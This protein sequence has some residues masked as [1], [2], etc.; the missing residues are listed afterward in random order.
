MKKLFIILGLL[1][2]T[3]CGNEELVLSG[4]SGEL[5]RLST[6]EFN[7]QMI[8]VEGI[9]AFDEMESIYDYDFDD[10][11]DIDSDLVSEYNVLYNED[12]EHFLAVFKAVDGEKE[13]LVSQMKD[14]TEDLE[15]VTFVEYEGYLIYVS[16]YNNQIVV[17]RVKNAT[18][19]IFNSMMEVSGDELETMIGVSKDDVS[20]FLVKVPMMMTQS[21]SVIIVKPIE[22]KEEVV[23]NELEVY[24]TKLEEQWET[25]LPDQYE[26]VKN[27]KV[28]FVGE[29]LVYIISSN[30]DLV[31]DAIKE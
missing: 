22:G 29:Y 18:T 3:G 20:E 31:F 11:F 24:M 9:G 17:E 4:L 19:P 28:E 15:N 23:K 21:S 10:I 13:E 16:S 6:G 27:R 1:V 2:F 5:D 8:D 25:Y 26:L 30:N 12:T 7:I 14:Y